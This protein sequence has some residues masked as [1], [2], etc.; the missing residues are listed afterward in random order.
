MSY[1]LYKD[2]ES[3]GSFLQQIDNQTQFSGQYQYFGIL[4]GICILLTFLSLFCIPTIPTSPGSFSSLS[5]MGSLC[6]FGS[7]IFLKGIKSWVDGMM[8]DNRRPYTYAYCGALLMTFLAS[9][10]FKNYLASLLGAIAQVN[11]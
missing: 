8:E 5:V 7:F 11:L 3:E 1:N 9:M 2:Q 10:I 4:F 6:M